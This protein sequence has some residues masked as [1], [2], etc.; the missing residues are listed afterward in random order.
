MGIDKEIKQATF[1]N[2]QNKAMVNIMFTH[3]WMVDHI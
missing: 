2:N 1:R 3:A